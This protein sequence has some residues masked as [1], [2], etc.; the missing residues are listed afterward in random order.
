MGESRATKPY[1]LRI[2]KNLMDLAEAKSRSERTDRA[3]ALRQLLY[4]GAEDYAMKLLAEGR[5]SSGKAAELLDTTVYRVHEL[6]AER[7]I[8][9]GTRLEDYRRSRESIAGLLG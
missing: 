9:I 2:P 6:A 8:E 7:G 5:I 3:T 1:P 4:A